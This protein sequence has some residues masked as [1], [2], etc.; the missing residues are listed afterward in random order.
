MIICLN[1]LFVSIYGCAY[2]YMHICAH[3]CEMDIKDICSSVHAYMQIGVYITLFAHVC[4]Y[5]C[6][7]AYVNT[8]NNIIIHVITC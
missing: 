5:M 4:A 1:G 8:C 7:S 2:I 3:M 6:G